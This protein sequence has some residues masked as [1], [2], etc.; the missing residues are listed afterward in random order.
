MGHCGA[1][2]T[3]GKVGWNKLLY[4]EC[5]DGDDRESVAGK[6]CQRDD[7]WYIAGVLAAGGHSSSFYTIK[8][9]GNESKREG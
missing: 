6:I 5:D 3:K 2:A 1:R 4:C 9:K 7:C 8:K